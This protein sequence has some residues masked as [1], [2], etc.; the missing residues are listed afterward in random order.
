VYLDE[1]YEIR[2]LLSYCD[3]RVHKG[4]IYKVSGFELYRIND[5]GMQTWR[6][7][8]PGLSEEEH[9]AVKEASRVDRRA[10]QFRAKRN[11]LSL[12]F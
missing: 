3:P 1:P 10:N 4:T 5:M 8:L 7:R 11:Q 6:K 2:W 12:P 9:A